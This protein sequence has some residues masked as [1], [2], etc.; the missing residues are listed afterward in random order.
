MNLL[1]ES[2]PKQ[3]KALFKLYLELNSHVKG[4]DFFHK[5]MTLIGITIDK[6]QIISIGIFAGSMVTNYSN[7]GFI[8]LLFSVTRPDILL[9]RFGYQSELTEAMIVMIFI[10]ASLKLFLFAQIYQKKYILRTFSI[11]VTKITSSILMILLKIPILMYGFNSFLSL[12]QL[13]VVNNEFS[14]EFIL[15]P[16]V[17]NLFMFFALVIYIASVMFDTILENRQKY[18]KKTLSRAHSIVQIQENIALIIIAILKCAIKD[19]YLL[20]MYSVFSGYIIFSHYYYSQ[21]VG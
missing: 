3:K 19:A 1:P 9:V 8:Q 13:T 14:P 21:L 10:N 20:L 11:F 2:L 6:L 7:R 17:L 12:C 5:A 18:S 16:L 4:S 15:Q